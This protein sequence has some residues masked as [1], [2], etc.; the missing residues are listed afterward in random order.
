M[1]YV[2][3]IDGGGTKTE[4]V[5]MDEG[6]NVVAPG[7]AGASNPV[8]VGFERA[9]AVIEQAADS[10]MQEAGVERSAIAALC[11][12]IAG[13]GDTQSAE[14]MRAG[15]AAAFPGM[16]LKICT[17]LDTALAAAGEGPAM[18][19]IAGTGSAAAARTVTGEMRR[20]GGLGPRTGDEGSAGDTGKKAVTAAKLHRERTGME[21]WLGKQLLNQLGISNWSELPSGH[22]FRG[23]GR[24]DSGGRS[25]VDDQQDLYPRLFPVVTNAADVGDEM[26]Q[27]L[28]RNAA[29][30][31]AALVKQLVD[32]LHLREVPFP[33]TKTGG[34]IGRCAF[35]DVELEK[36]LREAA[37]K[38]MIGLPV[39][40]PAHAAALMALKLIPGSKG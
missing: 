11:A 35:F 25:G 30:D 16:A 40:S 29:S 4:C 8:R 15:L 12:G 32:E 23:T 17:D 21:S 13:A 36:R 27:E 38:A 3:G 26:A 24:M 20:A 31:L 7:R 22:S 18:V 14:S 2:L 1:R 10:A 6:K 5:L 28:L 19:L 33:L 37:P 9:A 39:I 34:M